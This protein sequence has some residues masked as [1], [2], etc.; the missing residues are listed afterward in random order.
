MKLVRDNVPDIMRMIGKHPKTHFAEGK[1]VE[2]AL[3]A[4]LEEE[5]KEVKEGRNIEEIAD[6]IEVG[7]SLA[8]EYGTNEDKLNIIRKEKIIKNGGFNKKIILDD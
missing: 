5:L 3:I 6:L 1:E 4:K 2:E 8:K 7:Y